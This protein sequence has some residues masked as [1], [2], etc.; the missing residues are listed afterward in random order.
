MKS[1]TSFFILGELIKILKKAVT[2]QGSQ[3]NTYITIENTPEAIAEH[4]CT[5]GLHEDITIYTEDGDFLL[6]TFGIYINKCP[7]QRF[8]Q[9]E[10]LPVLIPMQMEVEERII[11][12]A[13]EQQM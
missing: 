2:L 8:L 3:G 10:L 1:H 12:G 7:N 4:I 13:M 5:Y 6:S 9:K 11:T